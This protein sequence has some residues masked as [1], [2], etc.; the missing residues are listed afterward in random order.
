MNDWQRY[1]SPKIWTDDDLNQSSMAKA[2]VT[3]ESKVEGAGVLVIT[4]FRKRKHRVE[5]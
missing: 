3:H 4:K 1:D 2:K 5:K